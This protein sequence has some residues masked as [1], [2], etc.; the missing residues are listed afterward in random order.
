MKTGSCLYKGLLVKTVPPC[1]SYLF[2]KQDLEP[3]M[4]KSHA[5]ISRMVWQLIT[6]V[7]RQS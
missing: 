6:A 3:L 7:C 5:C 4:N 2:T 1:F